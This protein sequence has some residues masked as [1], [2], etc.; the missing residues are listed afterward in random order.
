MGQ[1]VGAVSSIAA[2]YIAQKIVLG[3]INEFIKNDQVPPV[4]MSANIPGGDEHN[5]KLVKKYKKKIRNLY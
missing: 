1:K 3:V 4:F 2:I 5:A